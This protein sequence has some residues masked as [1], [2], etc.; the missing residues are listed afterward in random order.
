MLKPMIKPL[1]KTL[2]LIS[3][4][5]SILLV[6]NIALLSFI[7]TCN[8]QIIPATSLSTDTKTVLATPAYSQIKNPGIQLDE[9]LPLF[10][11]VTKDK[12]L[13]FLHNEDLTELQPVGA[14]VLV[15]DFDGNGLDDIYIT[16]SLG[17]NALYKN[18]DKGF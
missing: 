18:A 7:I 9:Y 10:Q 8:R 13:N 2:V 3:S 1:I 14:G 11:D 5:S 4:K 15:F 16:D 6:I 17:P 12:G